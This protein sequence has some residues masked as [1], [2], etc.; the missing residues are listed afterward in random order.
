MKSFSATLSCLLLLMSTPGASAELR[1][2]LPADAA[3]ALRSASEVEIYS[4]EPCDSAVRI[5]QP[6][7]WSLT[8]LFKPTPLPL[9][10][11]K[12]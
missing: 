9:L 7:V 6:P 8:I 5:L 1:N 10:N 12:R 11:H 3:E 4:L 2:G